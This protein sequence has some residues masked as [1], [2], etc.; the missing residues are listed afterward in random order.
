MLVGFPLIPYKP[1]TGKI[2]NR[3][4]HPIKKIRSIG[5]LR[6]YLRSKSQFL[7]DSG[8][9]SDSLC[10]H[11]GFNGNTTAIRS[12]QSDWHIQH[13]IQIFTEEITNGTKIPDA[14]R[15]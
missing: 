12:N 7:I 2:A 3:C 6:L 11:P 1:T 9:F 15:S 8:Y 5:S 10:R 13:F 14:F 4:Y